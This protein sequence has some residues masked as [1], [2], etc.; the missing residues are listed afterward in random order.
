MQAQDVLP[1]GQDFVVKDG[2]TLRKGSVAA[3]IGNAQVLQNP[4]ASAQARQD[5]QR[6]LVSLIPVLDALGLFD[7][8]ELRSPQLRDEVAR[9][10]GQ[11]GHGAA[12]SPAPAAPH[13]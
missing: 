8:F 12:L 1:D 10:R 7:V 9:H 11:G 13:A 6:D 5:A 2:V 3:F 4:G